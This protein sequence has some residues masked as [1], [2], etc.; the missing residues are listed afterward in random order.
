MSDKT[1]KEEVGKPK[2]E[3]AYKLA[4][5]AVD[6]ACESL[7]A[8]AR[9]IE[10][11]QGPEHSPTNM[12]V[13]VMLSVLTEEVGKNLQLCPAC[14]AKH[15]AH[16]METHYHTSEGV[17]T[18]RFAKEAKRLEK[19]AEGKTQEEKKGKPVH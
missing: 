18:C 8:T 6:A 17:G 13:L 12:T 11:L 10:T 2:A 1:E 5:G 9:Q 3:E 16:R 14:L 19:E 15:L 4:M 7:M